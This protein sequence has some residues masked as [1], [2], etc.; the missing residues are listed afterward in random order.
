MTTTHHS[1]SFGIQ[2]SGNDIIFTLKAV[3]TLTHKDYLTFTPLLESALEKI[4]SP[5]VRM[6]FD[7]TE[8]QGWEVEAAWDDLKI[9]L[10]HGSDFAK[11]AI[12]GNKT[13]LAIA[14]RIG[15][16][17]ISGDV[18]YFEEVELACRWLGEPVT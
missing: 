3:G 12:V 6:L 9:G 8:L 14:A 13:W 1:I 16:W 10:K 15:D 18:Q 5:Q 2:R 17:F 4:D 11:I 7:A